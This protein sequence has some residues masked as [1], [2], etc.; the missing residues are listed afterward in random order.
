MLSGG[1]TPR[2]CN[3]GALSGSAQ[4]CSGKHA[5]SFASSFPFQYVLPCSARVRIRSCR[6]RLG[7]FSA[8]EWS[9]AAGTMATAIT[10]Q[11]EI[12]LVANQTLSKAQVIADSAALNRKPA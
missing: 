8:C 10:Y 4:T 3:N 9:R 5:F 6:P 12:S 1:A 7:F 11:L 2:T